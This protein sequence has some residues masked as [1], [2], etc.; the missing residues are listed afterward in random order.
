MAGTVPSPLRGGE[1][2]GPAPQAWARF[3]RRWWVWEGR[4]W[5]TAADTRGL[6]AAPPHTPLPSPR[7]AAVWRGGLVGCGGR[8]T[9]AEGGMEA[10]GGLVLFGSFL[11]PGVYNRPATGEAGEAATRLRALK[12]ELGVSVP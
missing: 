6:P 7:N 1:G 12:R 10:C 4:R 9:A 5:L 8:V 2:S 11:F 3:P